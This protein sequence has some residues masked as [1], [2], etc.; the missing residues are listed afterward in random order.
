MNPAASVLGNGLEHAD[1]PSG[2]AAV[3]LG[4]RERAA[5][6][7]AEA[8]ATTAPVAAT[9]TTAPIAATTTMTMTSG[10]SAAC[11]RG[12]GRWRG[13][14]GPRGRAGAGASSPPSTV[15]APHH[16]LAAH[17]RLLAR[18]LRTLVVSQRWFEDCLK[19]GRRLPKKPYM[20]ESGE[21]AGLVP[22]LPTF[23]RS[24]SKKNASMEDICLKELPDDF[25]NTSYTT[26]VLVVA[27][28]G[29]DCEH[30]RWSDSSLLKEVRTI[31]S[32]IVLA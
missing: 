24:R 13:A 17:D 16:L 4:R 1:P 20:L 28:S 21:E 2:A 14:A 11:N 12:A 31:I 3:C 9:T 26:D 18:R 23:P 29:S 7:A 15:D 22:E 6:A 10:R 27:D 19:E 32:I 8:T 30:Q 5:T 25:C